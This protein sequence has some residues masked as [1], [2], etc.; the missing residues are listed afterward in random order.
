M[1]KESAQK[2]MKASMIRNMLEALNFLDG[3]PVGGMT[4]YFDLDEDVRQAAIRNKRKLR[5]LYDLIEELRID[6]AKKIFPGV[7]SFSQTDPRFPLYAEK[8]NAIL[9]KE[10]VVTFELDKFKKEGL[11]LGINKK[12]P[13][14][15]IEALEPMFAD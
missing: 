12:I 7:T 3:I 6:I 10:E 15:I 9:D 4:I 14:S 2:K 8:F 5:P 11:N 1:E 13:A